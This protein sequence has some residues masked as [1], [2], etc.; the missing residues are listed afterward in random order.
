MPPRLQIV[1]TQDTLSSLMGDIDTLMTLDDK[2]A[3]KRR[4]TI[5]QVGPGR[6]PGGL[7]LRDQSTHLAHEECGGRPHCRCVEG[8]GGRG[9]G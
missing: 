2:E 6:G 8:Q 7:W 3:P 9:G 4:M 1:A 5:L